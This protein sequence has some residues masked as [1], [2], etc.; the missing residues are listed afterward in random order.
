VSPDPFAKG[1]IS[2]IL[3]IVYKKK[4][5]L[6]VYGG[7][8]FDAHWKKLSVYNR[9]YSWIGRIVFRLA[10]AI[11]TDGLETH[12]ELKRRYGQ[13][14]FWKP[15]VPANINELLEINREIQVLKDKPHILYIGRLI[16]QKNIPFLVRVID[17]VK[18]L[19]E[20]TVVGD[21]PK[22]NLL[23][24]N[25]KHHTKLERKEI[26]ERFKE[27]D[28]LVLTSYFEGFARVVMEAAAAGMPVVTTKV[29][30]IQV[31]ESS[32]MMSQ[33]T[34]SIRARKRHS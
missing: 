32:R 18:E 21:G 10:D 25:V 5:L 27:A 11:Q 31:K 24:N 13:K 1:W 3:A 26:V 28:M 19:A 9:L 23:P 34:S 22:R 6:S 12:D 15:M 4:F 20:V 7:N 8:I 29:S 14:V 16:E 33:D 17:G 30:G 2:L